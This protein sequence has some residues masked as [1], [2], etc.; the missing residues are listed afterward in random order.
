[1]DLDERCGVDNFTRI[2]QF[3]T[4]VF[5]KADAP[6]LAINKAKNGFSGKNNLRNDHE[7]KL[8]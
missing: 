2:Y 7:T 4:N 1:M 8:D 6:I 5:I 3:A